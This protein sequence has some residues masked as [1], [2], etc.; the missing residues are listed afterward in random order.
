MFGFTARHIKRTMITQSSPDACNQQQQ[1]WETDGWYINLE[2]GLN[3]GAEGSAANLK[4]MAPQGCRDRYESKR[5]GPS[6]T[7]FPLIEKTTMY[8]ADGRV[9]MTISRE[10]VE[11]SRQPL[12]AA[13]FDIPAGYTE[14]KTSNE[15]YGAPSA[16]EIMAAQTQT[17]V[18]PASGQS[19]MPAA[20]AT[21]VATARAKVGVV[22]FNNK[23]KASV[24][25]EEL[26][27]QLIATLNGNGVEAVALNASSA[28]EAEIEAKAKGCTYILYTDLSTL[29]TASAGKK[30]GGFLGK[31]TGVGSGET[32]KSE[33]KLDYR[34][35]PVGGGAPKLQSSSSAKEDT[36]AA[37]INAALQGEARA[38]TGAVSNN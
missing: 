23:A 17:G 21:A 10:V 37:S 4:R 27:Q 7:G 8:G 14:A 32:G 26:R 33:T 3:C 34:L 29:K 24:S 28:S 25:T 22:E 15:M 31:A 9:V 20:P 13:L 6:H 11:L 5:T 30:L 16:A 38:V 2:Y 12:S 36:T 1:K 19:S 35:V 18:T